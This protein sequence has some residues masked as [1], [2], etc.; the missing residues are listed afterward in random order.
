M[1]TDERV[2][3]A[4][5]T[6]AFSLGLEFVGR[7]RE[8]IAKGI[9]KALPG[10]TLHQAPDHCNSWYVALPDGRQWR[11][12]PDAAV[13][14][15]G[16]E[17]V[18]PILRWNERPMV[19]AVLDAM[20]RRGAQLDVSSGLSV[21]VDGRDLQ[22]ADVARLVTDVENFDGML[23]ACLGIHPGR[24]AQTAKPIVAAW[25]AEVRALTGRYGMEI[26]RACPS[27]VQTHYAHLGQQ[28]TIATYH[29]RARHYGL[30]LH[31]LIYRG[32]VG[33]QHF[34]GTLDPAEVWAYVTLALG[35]VARATTA[36]AIRPGCGWGLY[37]DSTK[38]AC[39]RTFFT[40]H[41]MTGPELADVRAHLHR[42][43]RKYPQ[44][45]P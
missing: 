34:A 32:T 37:L 38:S 2:H 30:D 45:T 44:A 1:T 33:F 43:V 4:L 18:S 7:R 24:R 29:S 31:S 14:E 20:R 35:F 42:R 23:D 17:V 13:A 19:V 12:L 5:P 41:G 8:T 21:S 3:A 11:V 16:G 22:V 36:K 25:A 39:L 9:A 40:H 27:F 15:T 28:E 26:A 10:A 6:R